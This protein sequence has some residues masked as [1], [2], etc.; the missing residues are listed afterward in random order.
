M[1]RVKAYNKKFFE[2]WSAE[3]TYILGFLFADGNIVQTPRGGYYVAFHSSDKSLLVAMRAAMG[4]SHK[5][6]QRSPRSGGVY[7]LQIGSKKVFSDLYGLGLTPGK[8]QR[9]KFPAIPRIFLKDFI[10]GYFDGDGNVWK[11]ITHHN[12]HN[13]TIGLQVSFT[14]ASQFFLSALLGSIRGLGIGGGSLFALTGKNASRLTFA[15]NDALKLAHVMYN[16]P[17]KLYLPRK[18]RVFEQFAAMRP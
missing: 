14:S 18:R 3:M 6:S 13:D 11:G 2:E 4:S 12:T 17:C 5:V 1:G 8:A 9:M 15:T 10:R 16:A 7:R